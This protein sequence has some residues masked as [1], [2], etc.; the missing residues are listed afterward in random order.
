MKNRTASQILRLALPLILQ[1]LCLQ[2]QVWIDRAMLG[3]LNAVFFSAI[4]NTLVPYQMVVSTILAICGGTAILVAQG[5]GAKDEAAIR[6]AAESSFLGSTLLASVGFA[7]FFL[8]SDGLFRIMGVRG[9][10]LGYST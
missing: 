3:H 1:Q 10:V 5:S 7:C 4:G 6:S 9:E 2:L 8:C